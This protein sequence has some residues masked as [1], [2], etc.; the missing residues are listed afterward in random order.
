MIEVVSRP[1]KSGC[2]FNCLNPI[3]YNLRRED[4]QFNQ[5]NNNGGFA[6]IQINGSD[7]TDV[8]EVDDSVFIEGLGAATVTASSF[9]TNT[10]ITVNVAFEATATGFINNLSKRT[11]HKIEVEVFDYDTDESL[12]PRI[13]SDAGEDGTVKVDISGIVKSY[14]YADWEEVALNEVEA[15]TSKKVYIIIQEFYDATYWLETSELIYPIV[16]V[17]GFIPLLLNSPPNFTRYAHGGNLLS[18]F[19]EDSDRKFLNRFTKPSIWRGYPWSI[20]FCWPDAIDSIDRRV[21]QYD[22]EGNELSD[23]LEALET[24]SFS[25]SGAPFAP[26]RVH[27]LSVG[28]IHED[29]VEIKLSLESSA[30]QITEELT[31][32]VKDAC[33]VPI[34]LF[35]KNCVGGDQFWLFDESQEYEHTYPSGR[36]VKRIQLFADNLTL[37]EW[38]G[39][40]DMHSV[41]EIINSNIIDYEMSNTVDKTQFRNDQQVYIISADAE[42]LGVLTIPSGADTKTIYKKHSI[43]VTIE[44][45]E[46]FTV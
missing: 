12:G 19:P 36:K 29:A 31:L 33:E 32:K 2:N 4:F 9:S 23:D 7:E 27:R 28:T 8:F 44:L 25:G 13:V 45:P 40:N 3:V 20:S 14:L 30:V 24:G 38:D 1:I 41:S 10:L 34:P 22:S 43:Q 15:N 42:K 21:K 5:I 17:F 6:Q 35:W 18:Y 37:D 26:D 11:D 16:A 46:F 39:I